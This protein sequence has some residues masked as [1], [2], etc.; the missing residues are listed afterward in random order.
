MNDFVND[1]NRTIT[2]GP[3]Q[4]RCQGGPCVYEYT[5]PEKP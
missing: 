4:F 3:T 5:A 1:Y 2:I